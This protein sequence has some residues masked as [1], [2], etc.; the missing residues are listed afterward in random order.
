MLLQN[1]Q[2][3]VEQIRKFIEMR[4]QYGLFSVE[5]EA[6]GRVEQIEQSPFQVLTRFFTDLDVVLPTTL[7]VEQSTGDHVL[8]LHKP[9]FR[10]A[11]EI[12]RP[13]GT[14]LGTV[15]KQIRLGKARFSLDAPDGTELGMVQAENWRAKDFSIVDIQGQ[16]VARVTKKWRGMVTEAFTD[17]DTYLVDLMVSTEP[18]RS[19]A[20]ATALSIDLVM[21]EKD[22]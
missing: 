14:R 12:Q 15:T 2:I 22:A 20:L 3:V 9:W 21:K 5:G 17:A 6:I 11:V 13:D 18:M 4:N 7:A 1:Q 16:E 8:R 19:L 10:W